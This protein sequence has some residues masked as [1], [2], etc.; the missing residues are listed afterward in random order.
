MCAPLL[1]SAARMTPM[2]PAERDLNAGCCMRAARS[3][4]SIDSIDVDA[5]AALASAIDIINTSA[6]GMWG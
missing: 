6:T 5:C 1:L 3:I 4:D 2:L